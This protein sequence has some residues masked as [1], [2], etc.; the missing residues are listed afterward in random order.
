MQLKINLHTPIELN[1][2]F[3]KELSVFLINKQFQ[4]LAIFKIFMFLKICQTFT[5]NI[6]SVKKY[7]KYHI[8]FNA[9]MVVNNSVKRESPMCGNTLRNP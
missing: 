3:E 8:I 6:V 1:A 5:L 2:T 7:K 4:D 9:Y